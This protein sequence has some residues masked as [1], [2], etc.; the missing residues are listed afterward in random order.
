MLLCPQRLDN[1]SCGVSVRVSGFE[2]LEKLKLFLLRLALDGNNRVVLAA[3]VSDYEHLLHREP[4][5][6]AYAV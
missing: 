1:C 4:A 2:G 3:A 6:F 5:L